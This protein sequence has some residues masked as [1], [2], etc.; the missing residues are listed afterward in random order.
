MTVYVTQPGLAREVQRA[1]E[2]ESEEGKQLDYSI[3][4]YTLEVPLG[5]AVLEESGKPLTNAKPGDEI[6][7][8]ATLV[9]KVKNRIVKLEVPAALYSHGVPSFKSVYR[10]NDAVFGTVVWRCRKPLDLRKLPFLYEVYIVDE[11]VR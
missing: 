10:H 8:S 9:G 7:L 1:F 11:H 6:E 2:F 3:S 4:R 5:K